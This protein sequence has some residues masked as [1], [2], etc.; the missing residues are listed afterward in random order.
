MEWKKCSDILPKE[1]ETVLVCT[2]NKHIQTAYMYIDVFGNP[3]FYW[4]GD[5]VECVYA[6]MELPLL[7][8][9]K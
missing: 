3:E 1:E 4:N 2:T 6:W 5:D 7:P 8:N 9:F